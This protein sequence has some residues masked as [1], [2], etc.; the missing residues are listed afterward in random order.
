MKVVGLI[1]EYNPFHIGHK[2][3]IEESKRITGADYCVVVMS[4]NFVQRGEPAIVDKWTRTKIALNCGAD[5]VI[6]L[7]IAFSTASAE[8]FSMAAISLLEN[9]GIVNYVCFGSESGEITE[10]D[11]VASVLWAESDEFKYLLNQYLKQGMNFPK[12]RAHAIEDYLTKDAAII[13]KSPNNILGVEYLKALKK[14]KSTIEP[15]TIKRIGA[16]YH[17]EIAHQIIASA[18]AI[19]KYIMQDSELDALHNMVPPVSY[20]FLSKAIKNKTSP[21]FLGDFFALLKYNLLT[22][23][24]SMLNEIL[25]ITEGLENRILSAIQQVASMDELIDSIATKRYTRTKIHRAL[26]HILLNIDKKSFN[27]FTYNG[28]AQYIRVLGFNSNAQIL[29]KQLKEKAKLPIIVNVKDARKN[30]TSL[31]KK[32]LDQEILATNIY[33]AVILDKF[34]VQCKNDFTQPIVI[35][36]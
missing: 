19:R 8:F 12:A 4:G 18:T 9:T 26:L 15:F 1:A 5:M 29:M 6:E 36:D 11:K 2:I 10:L 21:I 25:D 27:V 3:H 32:M 24:P 17:D 28:Y 23:K 33:N 35:N 20:E 14:I 30:L 13:I 22:S 16:D 7:P 34:G 31:Q